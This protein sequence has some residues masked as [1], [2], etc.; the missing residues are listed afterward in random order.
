[1]IEAVVRAPAYAAPKKQILRIIEDQDREES[2]IECDF[3]DRLR[4]G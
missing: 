2:D 4:K 3:E 1:M